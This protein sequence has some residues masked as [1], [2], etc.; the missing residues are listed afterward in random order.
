VNAA[1]RDQYE[2]PVLSHG[3]VL[4]ALEDGR[5]SLLQLAGD[6]DVEHTNYRLRRILRDMEAA[7]LIRVVERAG[8]DWDLAVAT[9]KRRSK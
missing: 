5:D 6:F 3:N 7:A 1:G 9:T 4:S 2:A 8:G